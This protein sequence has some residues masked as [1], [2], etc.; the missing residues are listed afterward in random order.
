MA[1]ILVSAGEYSGDLHAARVIRRIKQLAPDVRVSG[2]GSAQLRATGADIIIDPTGINSVGLQEAVQNFRTH[3]AHYRQ[4]K[5]YV[6]H[7]RPRVMFLVDY[8]G[9]N[10]M[11]A[12]L[13]KKKGI[14]VVHYFAPSAWIWGRW[15]ARWMARMEATIAAVFPGEIDVY[16]R[17][18]AE[19]KFVGHPLLDIVEP[20]ADE[21]AVYRQLELNPGQKV[22]ALLPGSRDA[23]VQK[24]LPPML[25]AAA[26]LQK[27]DRELQFVIP[28]AD[29]INFSAVSDRVGQHR[30]I[31]RVVRGSTRK[32]MQISDFIISASGTATLEAAIL[33]TPMLIVYKT[34]DITYRLGKKLINRRFIGLPNLV[35][36]NEVVPELIQDEVSAADIFKQVNYYLRKPY[37]LKEMER[38]LEQTSDILGEKGAIDRT[39]N[40][41]L[42]KGAIKSG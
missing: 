20:V 36:D 5:E 11:M 34:S 19:V 12:R 42:E 21:E 6:V 13:G 17:A 7:F 37:L 16:R 9:F 2:M 10:M 40:L 41:V 14:P 28:L 24:L 1:R 18:G 22:L 4:L 26:R 3:L 29:S 8:S 35:A 33:G 23:E 30:L 25:E 39:A 38:S 32:V 15:R 31:A 27:H